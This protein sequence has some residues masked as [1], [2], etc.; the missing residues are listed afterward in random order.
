MG[1]TNN[2]TNDDSAE[3]I[4]ARILAMI[5]AKQNRRASRRAPIIVEETI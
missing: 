4:R 1:N 3:A 2:T 5:A